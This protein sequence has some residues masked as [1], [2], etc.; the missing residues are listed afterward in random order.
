MDNRRWKGGKHRSLRRNCNALWGEE[1]RNGWN[2]WF[3]PSP[4]VLSRPILLTSLKTKTV[5]RFDRFSPLA[6]AHSTSMAGGDVGRQVTLDSTPCFVSL[7][8]LQPSPS[9]PLLP[10]LLVYPC[11]LHQ[12]NSVR[13]NDISLSL[14]LKNS[15][16]YDTFLIIWNYE[17]TTMIARILTRELY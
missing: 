17:G 16:K 9:P 8:A 5:Y 14:F 7:H 13:S 10:T 1:E 15:S 4:R 12:K 6:N 2:G 11:D 3:H